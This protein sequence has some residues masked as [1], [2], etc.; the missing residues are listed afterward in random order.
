MSM[1]NEKVPVELI[2]TSYRSDNSDKAKDEQDKEDLSGKEEQSESDKDADSSRRVHP[3]L[4]RQLDETSAGQVTKQSHKAIQELDDISVQVMLRLAR[5]LGGD[6]SRVCELLKDSILKK[7]V[8]TRRGRK[9]FEVIS[10]V[11]LFGT[12]RTVDVLPYEEGKKDLDIHGNLT[13]YLLVDS[14]MTLSV[15]RLQKAIKFF[16]NDP[17]MQKRME[18]INE[19]K[20]H[21]D[22]IKKELGK[23]YD[24][25]E[26]IAVD[27][28]PNQKDN[29]SKSD[30]NS[31]SK[32]KDDFAD[33]QS[34]SQGYTA[35]NE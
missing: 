26:E 12:L 21:D 2:E 8:N 17:D 33:N 23:K 13:E 29:E 20:E 11:S 16:A 9:E 5:H 30:E 19:R 25:D 32:Y 22:I 3:S 24:Y 4:T 15:K 27:S 6:E 35:H 1:M 28:S 7:V 14:R 10:A 18:S 34:N 31:N